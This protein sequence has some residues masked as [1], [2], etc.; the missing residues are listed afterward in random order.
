GAQPVVALAAL[1]RH[2]IPQALPEHY[3]YTSAPDYLTLSGAN[4]HAR[5]LRAAADVPESQAWNAIEAQRARWV[6]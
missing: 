4:N 5:L 2:L 6:E 1:R 3:G